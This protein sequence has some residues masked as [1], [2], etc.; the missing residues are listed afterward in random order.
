MDKQWSWDSPWDVNAMSNY[1]TITSLAES[2]LQEG[3]LYAGTDDGFIHVTENGGENWQK[4]EVGS[5]PE[6]PET[7]F[8]N[9]IKADLFDA[10]T[11]YV[12]LDN[13]KY[14]DLKPYLLKSIN[15][16]KTWKSITGNI[17]DNTL[18]WRFVQDHIKPELCFIATEFG[19]YFTIDGGAQWVKFTGG[20]PTI[21]FRDLAIQKRENDLVGASF[22]RSFYVFDDYSILRDVSEDQLT[23]EATLFNS[24]DAWWYIPKM[25]KHAQGAS[26]FTAKNPPYGATFTYYLKDNIQ[27]IKQVRKESEKKLN[28]ENKDIPFPGWEALEVEERQPEPIIWLTVKNAEGKVIRRLSGP[29]EKGFHRMNWDLQLASSSVIDM[30][31]KNEDFNR[32]ANTKVGPGAYSVLLSKEIDGVI[33][34]LSGP[35][36][37]NVVPLGKGALKGAEPLEVA[38][39]WK[40]VH[41]FYGELSVT[42][43]DLKTAFKKVK[44]MNL[45]LSSATGS[46]A[47]LEKELYQINQ[48]LYAI[49][50]QLSGKSTKDQIG[51]KNKPNVNSRIQAAS[52]AV[53]NSTYGPTETAMMNLKLA[54]SKH[55]KIQKELKTIVEEQFPEMEKKLLEVGAPLVR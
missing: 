51:E 1:N 32:G 7:A 49:E 4:I 36:T 24:R 55:L 9:D 33:T 52:I 23:E 13:H 10:N 42:K 19:I 26:F 38:E 37:F 43:F 18:V 3:L 35:V 47:M 25:G 8:V 22:G 45:A 2:P 27:T 28:K 29:T 12:A 15:R 14:G 44:A 41:D 20:V 34:N 17:P 50:E 39:F 48:Q 21:S 30:N 5:L 53:K 54:K 46:V 31:S 40:E 16:G 11:I 6:V